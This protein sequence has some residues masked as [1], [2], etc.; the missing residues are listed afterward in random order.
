MKRTLF[1]DAVIHTGESETETFSSMLVENGRIA[2]L[3]PKDVKGAKVVSLGG[4]HVYPCLID[5]H[6]HLLQTIVAST[7]FTV[8]TIENGRIEPETMAGVEEK[9]RAFAATQP[10]DGIIV[11]A[12]YIITGIKERRLPSRQELDDWCGGRPVIIYS[13]DGHASALSSATLKKLGIETEG[14]SGVLMGEAHERI[15]GRLTDLIAGSV[16]PSVIAH[17]VANFHN[18]CAR[19]GISCVGALEGNGDSE[20]D[21]TTKLIV[22]LARRF[23][24][25]VRFYFQYI[26]PDKAQPLTRYQKHPRIGGCGDWEMDGAVGAHTAA[27]LSPYHDTGETAPTYYTQEFM[28]KTAADA[29]SRG[30]QIASHAIGTAAIDRILNALNSIEKP[31]CRHRI[32]H[33]EFASDEALDSIAQHGYAVM[34]QPGY[35]WIDKRFLHT[36]E[37]YLPDEILDMLS[38]KKLLDK[39]ILACGSSDSPVQDMDPWLQMMGMTEFYK[40]SESITPYEAFRCYTRNPAIAMLEEDERGALLPGLVADFFTA[41][42]NIFELSPEELGSFRP[43]ATYYGG[44]KAKEWRGTLPELLGMMLRKPHKV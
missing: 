1:T 3:D 2:E 18:A 20:K 31:C 9:I 15:Q 21:P 38:M 37:Q 22:Q 13:I 14:H 41:D 5:G 24:V 32:E 8:C 29:N 25:A 35:S 10:K 11:G 40:E 4:L 7:G 33:C 6:L 36:Y 19:Y 16:T 17:G 27:F 39:G 43:T 34:L 42:R 23:S 30:M 12:S 28:D 26:N 44:K